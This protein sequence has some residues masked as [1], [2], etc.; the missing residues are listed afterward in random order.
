MTE[1]VKAAAEIGINNAAFFAY[2]WAMIM[3]IL[4]TT[5][6][7]IG[8]AALAWYNVEK[9]LAIRQKRK[10]DAKNKESDSTL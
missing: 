4:P 10:H 5:V 7:I 9:A 1:K 2:I 8:G 3:D 6:T